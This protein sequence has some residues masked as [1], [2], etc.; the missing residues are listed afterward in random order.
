L[1]HRTDPLMH[2]MPVI[3]LLISAILD[4]LGRL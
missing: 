3:F 2:V 4:R 1:L